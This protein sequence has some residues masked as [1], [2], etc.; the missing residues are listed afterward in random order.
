MRDHVVER[1]GDLV[2]GAMYVVVAILAS[3]CLFLIIRAGVKP[4][5][6]FRTRR[7][8]KSPEEQEEDDRRRRWVR[9]FFGY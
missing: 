8:K 4:A 9:A 7:R 6:T 2:S 3:L 5:C 1:L